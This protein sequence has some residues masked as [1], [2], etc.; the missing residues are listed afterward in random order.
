MLAQ[1]CADGTLERVPRTRNAQSGA[2]F[3]ERGEQVVRL[4]CDCDARGVRGK[5]EHA[6]RRGG[7]LKQHRRHCAAYAKLQRV[8]AF[9]RADTHDCLARVGLYCAR[10]AML[11][12]T[13]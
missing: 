10:I 5:I 2:S 4:E 9:E 7:D 13:L 12:N 8:F 1:Q 3:Y 6:A 11:V